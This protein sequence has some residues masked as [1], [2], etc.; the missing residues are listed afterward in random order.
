M[1]I[2]WEFNETTIKT[3]YFRILKDHMY[4]EDVRAVA[5]IDM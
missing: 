5:L 3:N 2:W 4:R 1:T